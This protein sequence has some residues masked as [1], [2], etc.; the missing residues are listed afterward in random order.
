MRFQFIKFPFVV[1]NVRSEQR[2]A[3]VTGGRFLSVIDKDSEPFSK[4]ITQ[5]FAWENEMM[6]RNVPALTLLF[7]YEVNSRNGEVL[8]QLNGVPHTQAARRLPELPIKFSSPH[9]FSTF[10]RTDA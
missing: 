6:K 3:L 9:L 8:R 7:S 2:T 4:K 10:V 5:S 1:T